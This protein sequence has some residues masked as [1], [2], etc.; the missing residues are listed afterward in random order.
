MLML[1]FYGEFI[2]NSY[3]PAVNSTLYEAQTE[4]Y[5]FSKKRLT[6]QEYVHNIN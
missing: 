6:V 3:C 5:R 1:K 2:S 4:L